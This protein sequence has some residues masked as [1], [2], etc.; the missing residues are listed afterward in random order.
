MLKK[1]L[2]GVQMFRC[3]GPIIAASMSFLFFSILVEMLVFKHFKFK[4]VNQT[5]RDVLLLEI[6]TTPLAA[7]LAVQFS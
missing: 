6:H 7:D 1:S 5:L 2:F 3:L 4:N